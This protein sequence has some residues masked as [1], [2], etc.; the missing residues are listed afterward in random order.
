MT[1]WSASAVTKPG[2]ARQ[3]AAFVARFSNWIDAFP[4]RERAI[5]EV[6]KLFLPAKKEPP[7]EP[8]TVSKDHPPNA[9]LA[10]GHM[11]PETYFFPSHLIS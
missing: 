2:N 8:A 7:P 3:P 9:G 5:D 4:S 10:F 11:A 1:S 6:A